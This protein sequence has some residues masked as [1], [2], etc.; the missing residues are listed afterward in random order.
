MQCAADLLYPL[1][2][3]F[4]KIICSNHYPQFHII[5][6]SASTA[7]TN[8]LYVVDTSDDVSTRTLEQ[9]KSLILSDVKTKD[10]GKD[11]VTAGVMAYGSDAVLLLAPKNGVSESR[12]NL[13]LTEMQRVNGPRNYKAALDYVLNSVFTNLQ[14]VESSAKKLVIIL[15]DGRSQGWNKQDEVNYRKLFDQENAEVIVISSDP[16]AVDTIKGIANRPENVRIINPRS[17]VSYGNAISTINKVIAE[18]QGNF[19]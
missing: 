18:S 5:S 6:S 4:I 9:Y 7:P 13:V 15:T 2:S 1:F 14:F 17:P 12:V 16:R 10:L 19:Y 3:E 8:I 11:K